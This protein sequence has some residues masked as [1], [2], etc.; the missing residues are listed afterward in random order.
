MNYRILI[1]E[2]EPKI[3]EVLCDFFIS[4]GD[5]PVPAAD[6]A[7]ALELAER[8]QREAGGDG[9][10]EYCDTPETEQT[11]PLPPSQVKRSDVISSLDGWDGSG[12]SS[13]DDSESIHD[14]DQYT[15]FRCMFARES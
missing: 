15:P 8:I 12:M 5:I 10:E 13:L 11:I 1:A 14:E 9:S 6:G 3:R 7:Q 2:D 4:R